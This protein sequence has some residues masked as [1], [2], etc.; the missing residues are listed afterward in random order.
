MSAAALRSGE[1]AEAVR[2]GG[3]RILRTHRQAPAG[4]SEAL[5]TGGRLFVDITRRLGSPASRAGLL[6]DPIR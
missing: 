4:P 2:H 1:L 5:T 3:R 6:G